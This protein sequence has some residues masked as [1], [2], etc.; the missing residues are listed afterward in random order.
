MPVTGGNFDTV[1]MQDAAGATGNGE[2]L[3]IS[4]RHDGGKGVVAIDV[5]ISNTATVAF[6]GTMGDAQ[7]ALD[8]QSSVTW[9]SVALPAVATGTLATGATASGMFA[10]SNLAGLSAIRVRVSAWTSGTVT[11]IGRAVA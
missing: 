11:V 6:E 5:T 1:T 3:V 9:R 4:D 8:D 2:V 7:D 10:G